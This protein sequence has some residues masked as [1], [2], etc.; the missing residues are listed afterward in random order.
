MD[1]PIEK[2]PSRDPTTGSPRPNPPPAK[3]PR[4]PDEHLYGGG[5]GDGK[6]GYRDS[7]PAE[8]DE[9]PRRNRDDLDD[10]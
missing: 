3:S 5:G 8:R 10:S 2:R 4:N 6:P 9:S 1:R 7:D